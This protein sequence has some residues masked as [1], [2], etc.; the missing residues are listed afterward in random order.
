MADFNRAVKTVMIHEGKMSNATF[1]PGGITNYGISLRF[2]RQTGDLD[3]DGWP[4]GDINMD[5]EINSEDIKSLTVEQATRL[6]RLYF[7]DKN[8]YEKVHNQVLA[9]KL[10]DLAVNVG[11][12]AANKI[13]QRAVR[14][15]TGIELSE[16]GIM[17][18]RTLSA[19]NMGKPDR[20]LPA[21]KSEAAGYY[22]AIHYKGSHDFLTGWLNRAY[23]DVIL[24]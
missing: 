1:D 24:D 21:I 22:R 9:T 7:W 8:Q 13:A 2:L 16:D 5:G 3:H 18:L 17:G 12:Y 4:D 20:L 11:C 10:F 23:S 19:I 15:A 14:S 6:Y